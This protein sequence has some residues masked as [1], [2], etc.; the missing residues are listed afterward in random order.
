MEKNYRI[1]RSKRATT[2]AQRLAFRWDAFVSSTKACQS[3][4]RPNQQANAGFDRKARPVSSD[5][6]LAVGAASVGTPR[7]AEPALRLTSVPSFFGLSVIVF[8][9]PERNAFHSSL[10]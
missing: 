6:Q 9:R 3:S 2:K 5:F 4:L 7:P 8:Q 10:V 1:L